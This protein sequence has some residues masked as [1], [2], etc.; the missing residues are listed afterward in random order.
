MATAALADIH[1]NVHAL[2]AV[3]ADPRFSAA[4]EVVVLGDV[5]AG[6]FPAEALDVVLGLGERAQILRG[7]ADRIVL[8][9]EGREAAWVRE[10]L[11]PTQ[12]DAVRAWPLTFAVGVAGLGR[13]R[14]CHATPR[15]D[16]EIVTRS[17]PDT[18]LEAALEH[19]GDSRHRRPHSHAARPPCRPLALR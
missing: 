11:T 10:Q 12:L 7:N 1:G 8:E 2:A 14:C 19:S 5:V 18:D 15:G 9:E 6:T 4:E 3:L 13:V 16:E 17:T